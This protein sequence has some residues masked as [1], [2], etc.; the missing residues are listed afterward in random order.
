MLQLDVA[1]DYENLPLKTITLIQWFLDNTK[2]TTFKVDD[3]FIN[4][5]PWFLQYALWTLHRKSN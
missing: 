4:L 2:K 1:D 3:C 5:M